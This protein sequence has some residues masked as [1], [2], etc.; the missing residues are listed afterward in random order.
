MVEAL[1]IATEQIKEDEGLSLMPYDCTAG[2]LTIGYGRAIGINGISQEEAETLLINDVTVAA[3]DARQY[4]GDTAFEALNPER[5]AV[6]INMA[7]NLGLSRLRQFV[8]LRAAILESDWEEAS[9][10]ML[11]SKWADQVKGRAIRLAEIMCA[12]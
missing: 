3:N 4:L 5:Q 1:E 8:K 11:S 12:D 9:A 10:Q 7:F 6:L 2:V